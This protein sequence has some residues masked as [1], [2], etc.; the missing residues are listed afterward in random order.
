MNLVSYCRLNS[1]STHTLSVSAS[2]WVPQ[3]E[4]KRAR[5]MAVQ[6]VEE[7]ISMRRQI[8]EFADLTCSITGWNSPPPPPLN[9]RMFLNAA[10]PY[11]GGKV[12]VCGGRL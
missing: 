5:K 12:L 2:G 1:G 9:A 8:T 11:I 7:I 6:V 3:I 4:P 10:S